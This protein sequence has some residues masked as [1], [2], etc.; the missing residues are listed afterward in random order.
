MSVVTCVWY[1]LHPPI[2][3]CLVASLKHSYGQL[4][5]NLLLHFELIE[6]YSEKY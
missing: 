6:K 5:D 4:W 2:H 3:F 1:V